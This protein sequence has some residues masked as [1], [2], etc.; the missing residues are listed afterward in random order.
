MILVL[1]A[2]KEEAADI[3][4]NIKNKERI[5][6]FKLPFY[7][8]TFNNKRVV[9]GLTGVGKVMSAMVLQKLIDLYKPEAVIL[10]V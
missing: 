10:Q 2:M 9:V 6:Y 8:G 7:E 4:V 3:S 1:C 5:S